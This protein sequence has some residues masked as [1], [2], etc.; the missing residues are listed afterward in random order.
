MMRTTQ[1]EP[2]RWA[3]VGSSEFALR[4]VVPAIRASSG[5]QLCAVVTRDPARVSATGQFDDVL[6]TSRLDDLI[7][8]GVEIV[9]LVVPNEHHL[10]MTL[11]C[12]SLGLNVV[13]EK[14]MAL[15]QTEA[16]RMVAAASASQRMLAVG[17]C[18]AWSPA[19][20]RAGEL[21]DDGVLG[22]VFHAEISA[23][24]DTGTF[25]G[26]RQLTRT[27]EGGGVLNDLGA[28]AIDAAIRLL[29]PIQDVSAALSTTL[30]NHV[31]DDTAVLTLRH[32]GGAVSGL[33]LA[34]THGCNDFSITGANG[35]LTSREWLGRRFAGQLSREPETADSS[36]FDEAQA[37]PVV[38]ELAG[39]PVVDV[40]AR[41]V[42]E[43]S[44]AIRLGT[45]LNHADVETAMHVMA[46]I[47]AACRSSA[48]GTVQRVSPLVS[49][50]LATE[51]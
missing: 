6:V 32:V 2:V 28:H 23:A 30:P 17:S 21:I 47:E 45:P 35:R 22:T 49:R 9:H 36:R 39:S 25:R 1:P 50:A 24:F 34:F 16:E 37:H 15:S 38:N 14:P 26:W 31:A 29:G 20:T 41:Q 7:G 13:V 3:V 44:A 46:V 10:P 40:V 8:V 19:V 5:V 27:S 18:M 4:S 42:D 11:E 43:V 48:S 51:S 12:F 33:H